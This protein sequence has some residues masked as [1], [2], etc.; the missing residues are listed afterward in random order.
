MMVKYR[1]QIQTRVGF[2]VDNLTIQAKSEADAERRIRQMYVDC[3]VIRQEVLEQSAAPRTR[4]SVY[5]CATQSAQ[6]PTSVFG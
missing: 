3:R 1:F 6:H 2:M 4:T 5:S